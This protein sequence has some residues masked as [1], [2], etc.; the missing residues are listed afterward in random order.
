MNYLLQEITPYLRR[1]FKRLQLSPFSK[2][3]LVSNKKMSLATM[4]HIQQAE[5]DPEVLACILID[6]KTFMPG[7]DLFSLQFPQ[8]EA[9]EGMFRIGP[10]PGCCSRQNPLWGQCWPLVSPPSLESP[11]SHAFY[12]HEPCT[13]L[14]QQKPAKIQG[15]S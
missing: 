9:A 7:E 10:F 15:K 4:D 3:S 1:P 8:L 2:C 14:H 6:L 5:F 12:H 11:V 13:G